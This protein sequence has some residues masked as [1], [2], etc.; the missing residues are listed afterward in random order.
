MMSKAAKGTWYDALQLRPREISILSGAIHSIV[1]FGV[2]NYLPGT[3][4]GS[5]NA[6]LRLIE[7]GYLTL[8]T[9]Q[10]APQNDWIVV[11]FTE[12]NRQK[13]LADAGIPDEA[14]GEE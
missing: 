1:R 5:R 3:G 9:A 8:G 12:E 14:K 13:L 4:K 6:A 11:R 2:E 7:R 10:M